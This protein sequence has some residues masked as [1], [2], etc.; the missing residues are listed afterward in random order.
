MVF[1]FHHPKWCTRA[2][3][4]ASVT[5]AAARDGQG[6]AAAYLISG[7]IL[8]GLPDMDLYYVLQHY[9]PY[10]TLTFLFALILS[11]GLVIS[12]PNSVD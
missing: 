2:V 4:G 9:I 8:S 12:R 6:M 10:C 7:V 1:N 5:Y 11:V 3:L